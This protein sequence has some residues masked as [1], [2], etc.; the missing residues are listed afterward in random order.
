VTTMRETRR[1]SY[2]LNHRHYIFMS[3]EKPPS[4]GSQLDLKVPLPHTA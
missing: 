3:A 2:S 4:H 1:E